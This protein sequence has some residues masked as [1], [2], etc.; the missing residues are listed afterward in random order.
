MSAMASEAPVRAP[1]KAY[2]APPWM[3]PW[4]LMLCPPP[5]LALST[6]TDEKPWRRRRARSEEHTPALQSLMRI[7]HAVF[8][9]TKKSTPSPPSSSTT[10]KHHATRPHITQESATKLLH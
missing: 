10:H 1:C 3:M 6:N 8:L 4:D 2:L 7:S 9:S 5:R